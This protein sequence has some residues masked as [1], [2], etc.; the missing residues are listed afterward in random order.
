MILVKP[1]AAFKIYADTDCLS[2]TAGKKYG[3]PGIAN[4]MKCACDTL[5]YALL[6]NRTF[7]SMNAWSC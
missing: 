4:Q 2:L 6:T 5:L 1:L 7:Q 3:S